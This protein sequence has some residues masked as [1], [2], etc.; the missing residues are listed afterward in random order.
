MGDPVALFLPCSVDFWIVSHALFAI[1]AIAVPLNP[2][3]NQHELKATAEQVGIRAIVARP[4]HLATAERLDADLGRRLTIL[5]TGIGGPLSLGELEKHPP[6]L[7]APLP[8]DTEAAYLFSSGSTGRSKVVPW[9]QGAMIRAGQH[10]SKIQ[11]TLPTDKCLIGLP[12][13]TSFGFFVGV[14]GDAFAGATTVFWTDPQPIMMA[15]ARMLGAIEEE[16]ITRLPGVPFLFDLLATVTNNVDMS[17]VRLVSSGGVALK[18]PTF[19]RFYERFGLPIRQALGMTEVMLISTN[20]DPDPISTWD[21]VG[22]PDSEVTV[23]IVPTPDAPNPDVGEVFVKTPGMTAGYKWVDQAV[24]AVFRN[25]GMMTGD[26]GRIAENGHLYLTGRIK[27]IVEVSGMKVDPIEVEDVLM[28]HPAVAEA[29]V[30]G[31]PDPRTGE[32]RLKAVIV[33]KADETADNILRF[34]RARLTPHKVPAV[35]EFREQIPRNATGKI[36]RGQ[37]I[38]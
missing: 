8:E 16:R 12:S 35:L 29:V 3:A 20:S 5:S 33:R 4:E 15:R 21:S 10:A 31:V 37:L 6:A 18:K 32:Q 11:E 38:D 34:S 36:L 30:V 7:L 19:D 25:G 27:L 1:G 13:Y 17:S 14:G 28:A 23:E 24:N 26:L 9:T 22:R 2:Q